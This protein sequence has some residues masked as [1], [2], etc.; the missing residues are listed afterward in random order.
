MFHHRTNL[1]AHCLAVA[2][3]ST[4]LVGIR[5]DDVKWAISLLVSALGSLIALYIF[6]ANARLQAQ[7]LERYEA[8]ERARVS[9]IPVVPIRR[10]HD[11]I[12]GDL[13][14]LDH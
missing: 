7:S 9:A 10:P 11:P 13:T 14:F 2:S 8:L 3:A 1:E 5:F 12:G 6:R 4:P